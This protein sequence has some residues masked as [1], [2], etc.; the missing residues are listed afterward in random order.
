MNVMRKLLSTMCA[1]LLITLISG[2]TAHAESFTTPVINENRYVGDMNNDGVIDASDASAIL[3]A[4]SDFSIGKRD[5]RFNFDNLS[6]P[7][8]KS[9]LPSA[10]S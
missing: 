1:A 6:F 3:S 9:A 8:K 5:F 4:Y 10:A 7:T 2:T